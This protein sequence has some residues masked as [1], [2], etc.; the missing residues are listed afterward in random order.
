MSKALE[1]W[2]SGDKRLQIDVKDLNK[3]Y[4]K[5]TFKF[6]GWDLEEGY[7][8]TDYSGS[9][10]TNTLIGCLSVDTTLLHGSIPDANYPI[11]TIQDLDEIVRYEENKQE[12]MFTKDMLVSGAHIVEMRDG[13]RYLV[14]G[15]YII[16]EDGYMPL[17]K[18]NDE[19]ELKNS[20]RDLDIVKVFNGGNKHGGALLGAGAGVVSY[21]TQTNLPVVWQRE[22]SE[23][24]QKR[25]EKEKQQQLIQTLQED[26]RKAQKALQEASDKLEEM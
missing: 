17:S 19:L 12:N 21:I 23:D 13:V 25:L 1:R 26:V 24:K 4:V 7:D 5:E 20:Y 18:Y 15:D 6:L 16:G 3:E 14:A 2:K 9:I 8:I 10:W 22:F 11:S